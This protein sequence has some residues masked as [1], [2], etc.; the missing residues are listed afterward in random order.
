MARLSGKKADEEVKVQGMNQKAIHDR[1]ARPARPDEEGRRGRRGA[2]EGSSGRAAGAA[3]VCRRGG[4]LER[5]AGYGAAE[6]DDTAGAARGG[7]YV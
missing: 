7:R 1:E 2:G 3:E 6:D 4:A 5:A